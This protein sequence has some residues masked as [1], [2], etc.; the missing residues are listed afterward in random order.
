MKNKQER[1]RH[2][3]GEE[4]L[5]LGYGRDS[6]TLEEVVIYEG[7][8]NSKEFGDKPIWI[9]PKKEFFEKIERDGKVFQR[10]EKIE[11]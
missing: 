2:F 9:R 8:Y 7:Q 5:I 3:K 6:D 11:G 1:Y 10:F 4:Y